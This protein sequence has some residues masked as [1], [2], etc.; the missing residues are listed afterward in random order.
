MGAAP[1]IVAMEKGLLGVAVASL[2]VLVM[3]VIALS[4]TE[5]AT[6]TSSY[7]V[8][9][10][11]YADVFVINW[12]F[13]KYEVCVTDAGSTS[14]GVTAGC[15][16]HDQKYDSQSSDCGNNVVVALLYGGISHY[17]SA[18]GEN[19]PYT[20]CKSIQGLAAFTVTINAL[21]CI[22]NL[23]ASVACTMCFGVLGAIFHVLSVVFFCTCGFYISDKVSVTGSTTWGYCYI[24]LWIN[25]CLMLGITIINF[26][27][28]MNARKHAASTQGNSETCAE[29]SCGSNHSP[30]ASPD[31]PDI[32]E[33]PVSVH[34]DQQS[35]VMKV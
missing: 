9:T 28:V 12:G 25:M 21:G 5:V 35:T 30:K 17:V 31:P 1:L 20:A 13:Y 18:T 3:A 22:F 10:R 2:I 29:P 16:T 8:G 34:S 4:I 27:A 11:T 6:S 19:F 32:E 15:E 33:R 14:L 24:V 26:L 23:M 7:T